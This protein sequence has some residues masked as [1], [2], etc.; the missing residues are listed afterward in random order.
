MSIETCKL[1]GKDSTPWFHI[2]GHICGS[3]YHNSKINLL[4]DYRFYL[5][6]FIGAA[7][8]HFIKFL[9]GI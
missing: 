2:N 8:Y 6:G 5:A 9:I 3:C 7:I 1:C 4:K